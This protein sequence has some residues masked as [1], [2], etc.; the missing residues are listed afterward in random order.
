MRKLVAKAG[1]EMAI[2]KRVRMSGF[3]LTTPLLRS[4]PAHDCTSPG[5]GPPGKHFR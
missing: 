1:L 2:P 3:C 4:E 5:L